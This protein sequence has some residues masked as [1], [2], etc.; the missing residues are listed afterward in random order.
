MSEMA[1]VTVLNLVIQPYLVQK[2]L[3]MVP[4]WKAMPRMENSKC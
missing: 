4:T 2:A 1:L 3:V